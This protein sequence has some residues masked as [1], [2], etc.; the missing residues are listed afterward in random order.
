MG[1]IQSLARGLQILERIAESPQGVSIT[2]LAEVFG[3]DKG[4]VS[5]LLQTLAKYGFAEKVASTRRYVL[6]AQVVRL[7]RVMLARM[8][9]RETAR[10][11]LTRLVEQ[12]GECAHLAILAQGQALY[13]DQQESPFSLR[14]TTGVGTMAPLF[15]TALGKVLLAFCY[16]PLPEL[17]PY[18][19]RTITDPLMLERHLEIVRAQGYAIDDEEYNVGVRCIAVPVYDD[20]ASCVAAI[21]ISGPTSRLT[22]EK[23]PETAQAVVA[24]GKE[25]SALLGF[26]EHA[27]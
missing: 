7:S 13:I 17:K 9:L 24:T 5:R 2:E 25:L 6:G 16:L 27:S 14:V 1:E 26:S 3:I 11:F 10:P 23:I 8:P 19:A 21:G 15:C 4:S 18:T 12:T 22:L 20:R